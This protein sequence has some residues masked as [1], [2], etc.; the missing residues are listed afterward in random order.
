M[1]TERIKEET[2]QI[3]EVYKLRSYPSYFRI[4]EKSGEQDYIIQNIKSGWKVLVHNL[5][6]YDNGTIEWDFSSKGRFEPI[7]ED[8]D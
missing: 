7:L 3:G 5:I 8:D 4:L 6:C 2:P 1:R